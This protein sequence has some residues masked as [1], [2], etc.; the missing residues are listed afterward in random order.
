MGYLL[1]FFN[2]LILGN[3]GFAA[4]MFKTLPPCLQSFYTLKT[5]LNL[6]PSHYG[7]VLNKA[8]F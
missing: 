5:S 4:K 7:I 2:L 1:I 6:S 8:I 3:A